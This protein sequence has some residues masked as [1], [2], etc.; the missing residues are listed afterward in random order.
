MK[1]PLSTL[2]K[3]MLK[4]K[5]SLKKIRECRE[6]GVSLHNVEIEINGKK[7][8]ISQKNIS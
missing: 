7:Y 4:S 1:P 2:T 8:V 5:K 3:E 6:K